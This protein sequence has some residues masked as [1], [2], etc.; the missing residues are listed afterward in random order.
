[1]C[2]VVVEES[3]ALV[4]VGRPRIKIGEQ[5][6]YLVETRFRIK[7]IATIFNCS[8]RTIERRT[9][10]LQISPTSYTIITDTEFD[11]LVNEIT[12]VHPHCGEKS[13]SG[14][15]RSQGIHVQRQRVRDSFHRV[16]PT[17]IERR[18]HRVLCRREYSVESPNSLRHLDGYNK[19]VRWR[20]VIHGRIDGYSRLITFLQAATNNC[21]STVLSAFQGAVDEYGLPSQIRMDRGG[22]NVLVSQF[23]LKHP[24]RGTERGSVIVGRSVHNQRIERLWRDLYSGCIS[25]FYNFFY[26]LED[27]GVLNIVTT[28]ISM[29]FTLSLYH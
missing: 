25:F 10:E 7:D 9:R 3:D 29:H 13:V 16:D 1:M 12:S 28:L 23:M 8:I 4:S 21:A 2:N 6:Q 11:G 22:K 24:L 19:L 26:F 5:L 27:T 14:R 17:G 18:K 20:I 15:L